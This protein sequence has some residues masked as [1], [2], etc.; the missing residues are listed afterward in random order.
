WNIIVDDEMDR[1]GKKRELD[2]SA[3]VLVA[4]S[5]GT[6]AETSD[7]S[8]ARVLAHVLLS[9]PDTSEERRWAIELDW[10]E[11]VTAF[12]YEYYS[13]RSRRLANSAEYRRYSTMTISV[14]MHLDID[15]AFSDVDLNDDVYRKLRVAYDHLSQAIKYASDIGSLRRELVDEDNLNVVR[16]VA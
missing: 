16:I 9:L 7:S 11:L 5:L 12:N 1:D 8:A 2:N 6:L 13:N 10:W 4:R 14:K 3:H 15:L